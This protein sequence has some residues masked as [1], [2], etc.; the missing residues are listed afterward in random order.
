MAL[1]RSY[2]IMLYL[3]CDDLIQQ[4]FQ[5]FFSIEKHHPDTVKANMLSILSLVMGDRDAIC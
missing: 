3:V 5:C 4:M 2:D 1:V